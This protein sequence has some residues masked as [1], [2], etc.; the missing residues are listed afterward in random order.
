MPCAWAP[1]TTRSFRNWS[2][3][4]ISFRWFARSHR[5]ALATG[6]EK[7]STTVD[8]LRG[9]AA[10]DLARPLRRR[11]R[12]RRRRDRLGRRRHRLVGLRRRTR[13]TAGAVG[14]GALL[15]IEAK[16]EL[17]PV[18]AAAAHRPDARAAGV[19][20]ADLHLLAAVAAAGDHLAGA[21]AVAPVQVLAEGAALL[22]VAAAVGTRRDVVREGI[23][24]VD[25]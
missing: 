4:R 7:T 19:G 20:A 5:R 10:A 22:L 13:R 8:G 25:I 9:D 12:R 3:S 16:L 11:R 1:L 21:R 14:D 24:R 18:R 2:S 6:F 23:G 15:D 17:T